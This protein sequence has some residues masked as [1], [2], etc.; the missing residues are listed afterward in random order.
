MDCPEISEKDAHIWLVL[1]PP[2]RLKENNIGLLENIT[3]CGEVIVITVSQPSKYLSELYASRGIPVE[4]I[5]FIDT[6]SKFAMG[7]VESG[8]SK[9]RF[10][11]NPSDLT[12]L[13]IAVSET[14]KDMMDKKPSIV[15]DSINAM[16][17][18]LPSTDI[19]KFMHFIT[20]KLRIMDLSGIYIAAESSLDPKIMA[21]IVTFT[22]KVINLNGDNMPKQ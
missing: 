6:I 13:S 15:I 17:I 3:K 9:T 16:L 20:S 10:I 19:T 21:Q 1:S 12:G 22:D 8:A 5:T 11:N 18:Y 2:D 4:K 7:S 14:L